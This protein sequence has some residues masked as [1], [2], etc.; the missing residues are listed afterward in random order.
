MNDELRAILQKQIID[1]DDPRFE[2]F[3]DDF[4]GDFY[5][6]FLNLLKFK[7]LTNPDLDLDNLNLIPYL[8]VHPDK[9]NLIGKMAYSYKLGFDT[10]LNFLNGLMKE[11]GASP[12]TAQEYERV[13]EQILT[14]ISEELSSKNQNKHIEHFNVLL[15]QIFQK[16]NLNK[17]NICYQLL[18]K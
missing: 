1:K 11:I 14:K 4:Y 12:D 10:K 16:Y 6:F 13:Q 18:K 5:D 3:S 15:G 7:G 2:F 9:H 17:D 8:D